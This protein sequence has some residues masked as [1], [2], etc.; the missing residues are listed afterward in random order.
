MLHNACYTYAYFF[1]ILN[2]IKI[3]FGQVLVCC[4]AN[5]SNK[6]LAECWRLEASS[7]LFYDFIKIK[8]QQDL[9][10]FNGWHMPF[11]IAFIPSSKKWNTGILAYLVIEQLGQVAKLK[12]TWNLGPGFKIFSKD[13]WELLSLLIS[14]NW[15]SLETS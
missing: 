11:L 4:M 6:F 7:R 3:K 5:I 8:I 1:W 9:A 10:F 2:T 12:R 15:L 14:I 13:Y